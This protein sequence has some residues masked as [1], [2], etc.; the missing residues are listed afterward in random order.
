MRESRLGAIRL[1]YPYAGRMEELAVSAISETVEGVEIPTWIEERQ[2]DHP[3]SPDTFIRVE[4]RDGSPQVVELTWTSQPHQTEIKQKHLRAIELD[5]LATDLVATSVAAAF[6]KPGASSNDRERVERIAAKFV[7]RQ[8]LPRD[9]R[10]IT[11]DFLKSVADVYRKNIGHAPARAVAKTFG[12][13]ARM[14]S[15]YVDRARR[16]GHLPPT[17]RGKKKA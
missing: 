15:T 17:K 7:E 10:V 16:A 4:L 6:S 13:R 1:V 2:F 12:V 9:Y 3:T 14:A 11:D 5:K 8:R